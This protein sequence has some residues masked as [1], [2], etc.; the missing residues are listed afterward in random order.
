VALV[1]AAVHDPAAGVVPDVVHVVQLVDETQA[2]H[3]AGHE[4]EQLAGTG[5]V[6]PVLQ[7]AQNPEVTPM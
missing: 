5:M 2:E 6:Y 7:A 3:P 4:L 1:A